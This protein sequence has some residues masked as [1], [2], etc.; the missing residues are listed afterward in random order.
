MDTKRSP[1]RR[2]LSAWL[3]AAC[4]PTFAI[5]C[6]AIAKESYLDS[7]VAAFVHHDTLINLQY[8]PD[9]K[10]MAAIARRGNTTGLIVFQVSDGQST[11][12]Q[13][14]P[15]GNQIVDVWWVSDERLLVAVGQN[16]GSDIAPTPTGELYGVNFDGSKPMLLAGYRVT[17]P[18]T[19]SRIGSSAKEEFASVYLLDSLPAKD[20][21]VLVY[22][23]PHDSKSPR[24][25]VDRMN[26]YTGRRKTEVTAPVS[27]ARFLTDNASRVR[28][29][30]ASDDS[31]M[32]RLY[33]R[34]VEGGDWQLVSDE[35]RG[36]PIE[37]PLGFGAGDRVAYMQVEQET[38]PDVVVAYDTNTQQRTVVAKD[39]IF[40]PM[41][42]YRDG[43]GEVIGVRFGEQ[44]PRTVYFGDS[45]EESRLH[46]R[47][48]RS[49]ADS[50]LTVTSA[51][52]DGN[53]KLLFLQS[54]VDPGSY[55]AY[56]VLSKKAS[57]LLE[58][59][60][61]INPEAMS[62]VQP[63][64]FKA[65]DGMDIH[66]FLT[67]PRM[68]KGKAPL[69]V[70]PHGGPFG[71]YDTW[72]FNNDVQL[73][74]DAGYAVLQVNYR[75]S[76]NHGRAYLHAGA[77][78]WGGRMQDDLTDATH[79]A[80]R[81]PA[82]DSARACIYGASYGGYAAM[83]G[84]A[85]EPGLYRCA[86]G[87]LGVYDLNLMI[88]DDTRDGGRSMEKWFHDWV[89]DDPEKLREH[90]PT[91]LAS[92]I[93]VPVLVAW[94]GSDDIAPSKQSKAMVSA[95]KRANVAVETVFFAREGHGFYSAEN[96]HMFYLRLLSFLN[97]H[98]GAQAQ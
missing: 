94:A 16:F 76:G 70:M 24:A 55:Y 82:I 64:T 20:D 46:E 22:V 25:R 37:L 95:L 10:H 62:K 63:F 61:L 69:I 87:A 1:M 90:S 38:G 23:W 84:V 54:D 31:N 60:K 43:S 59:Q 86:V 91:Y 71:V 77:R 65:R 9:G 75:G 80:F 11:L 39:A 51:T 81:N 13:R 74:A 73:L 14:L 18:T 8:S 6:T 12:N 56:D 52:R 47:L 96:Q 28:F 78:E 41:P 45:V 27:K 72:D 15:N 44:K 35:A 3:I 50:T 19:G 98:L 85:K 2:V 7:K 66:G 57:F 48:Q 29:S 92:R 36:D 26:V 32:S 88:R 17:G 4:L 34:G 68:S 42:I 40:D 5:P 83:M 93:N 53:L 49:F 21:E 33:H 97:Q 67:L 79:W 89:G 58:R 30:R